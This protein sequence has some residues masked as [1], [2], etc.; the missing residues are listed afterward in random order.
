MTTPGFPDGL[1]VDSYGFVY[2]SAF[3]GVQVFAPGTGELVCEVPL[4]GA[5]NFAFG[6]T[7]DV[8]YVT[9]DTAIWAAHFE[10][11]GL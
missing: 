11:K 2:A 9:T 7:E 5:V 10:T 4:A 6:E 1:K 8:L 3:S